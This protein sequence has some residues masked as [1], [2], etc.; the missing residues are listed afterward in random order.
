VA[1]A[2]GE[3]LLSARR[4][5][6]DE[7][8]VMLARNKMGNRPKHGA[9]AHTCERRYGV[10]AQCYAEPRRGHRINIGKRWAS[11]GASI[12]EP[13]HQLHPCVPSTSAARHRERR[14][15]GVEVKSKGTI[16]LHN[17]KP[18]VHEKG[19]LSG[20]RVGPSLGVGGEFRRER[21]RY[22]I[23]TA[24][25]LRETMPTI[26]AAGPIGRDCDPHTVHPCHG[27]GG[28][29]QVLRLVDGIPARAR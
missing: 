14:R 17:I 26:V 13:G 29:A 7:K 6:S 27:R 8:L 15:N 21:D 23:P 2:S 4:F 12:G 16:R 3:V 10:F 22:K 25:P 28:H 20:V 18:C 11:R 5:E 24:P 1:A 9:F 19:H